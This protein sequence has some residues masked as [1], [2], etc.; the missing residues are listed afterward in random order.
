MAVSR[1]GAEYMDEIYAGIARTMADSSPDETPERASSY[2]IGWRRIS[3]IAAVLLITAGTAWI[4]ISIGRKQPLAGKAAP[5]GNKEHTPQPDNNKT[6][7]RIDCTERLCQ[8]K[9][10]CITGWQH[11]LAERSVRS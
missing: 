2:R 3:S 10:N 6:G 4:G 11:C 8:Q 5:A 9:E 1:T 7:T